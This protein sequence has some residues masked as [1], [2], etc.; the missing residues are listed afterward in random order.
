MKTPA[1]SRPVASKTSEAVNAETAR[2]WS[3]LRTAQPATRSPTGAIAERTRDPYSRVEVC[4]SPWTSTT[5]FTGDR[6]R[7]RASSAATPS[8]GLS[9]TITS[10]RKS[11]SSR[12]ISKG[13][14]A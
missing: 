12:A 10:G 2:R 3:A 11:R 14:D 6:S 4:Q 1:G 5:S 8:Y 13:K 7:R 9:A